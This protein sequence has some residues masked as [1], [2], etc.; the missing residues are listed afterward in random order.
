MAKVYLTFYVPS[1]YESSVGA[2]R[3]LVAYPGDAGADPATHF[4]GNTLLDDQGA[5]YGSL[6]GT[7]QTIPGSAHAAT[8]FR[9]W[10]NQTHWLGWLAGNGLQ[11]QVLSLS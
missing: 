5:A 7:L 9:Q 4:G 2:T 3:A 10:T 1:G 11:P 8:P 6:V